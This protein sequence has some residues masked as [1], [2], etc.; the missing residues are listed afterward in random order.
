MK[1]TLVSS[2][3]TLASM[4]ILVTGCG[5]N[6]PAASQTGG[7]GAGNAGL[8]TDAAGSA[9]PTP[10]AAPVQ[11]GDAALNPACAVLSVA[12]VEQLTGRH[13]EKVLGTTSPGSNGGTS[14]SCTWGLHQELD[15]GAP[16]VVVEYE[17][18]TRDLAGYRQLIQD[19]VAQQ[20]AVPVANL[21]DAASSHNLTV[22]VVTGM[23]LIHVR[24]ELHPIEVDP[25]QQ[26]AFVEKVAR[27]VVP[28]VTVP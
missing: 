20:L 15:F 7:A 8:L 27:I 1:T 22:D 5:G 12:E 28:R 6:S 14:R 23:T 17:I 19:N 26:E 18:T 9:T 25:Q 2:T 10:S 11:S 16:A 21:G 4:L 3:L 24:V 13:V